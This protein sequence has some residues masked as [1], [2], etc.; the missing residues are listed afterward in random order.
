MRLTVFF[1]GQFWAGV[2]ESA[3]NNAPFVSKYIFGA[4]PKDG[5]IERFVNYEMIK[6]IKGSAVF[7]DNGILSEKKKSPKRL[8]RL[9][10]KETRGN[11][12]STKSQDVLRK[13]MEE[14]KIARQKET[15]LQ[16]EEFEEIKRLKAV[17]KKKQKHKGH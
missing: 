6:L 8:K 9:A 3:V 16:R 13:A 5:Q 12:L 7:N 10:A 11:P 17:E 1:D 2:I 15:R 4:E 14:N